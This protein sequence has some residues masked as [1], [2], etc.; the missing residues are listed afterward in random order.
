MQRIGWIGLGTMGLPMASHL[1]KA[2]YELTVYNR[3]PEKVETLVKLGAKVA[4]SPALLAK[5]QE[6][7]FTML[8]ADQAVEEVVLGKD[9]IIHGADPNTIVV[10]SSTIAASTSKKVAHELMQK[11]IHMLDAPVTGSEPQANEGLLTFMV[12]GDKEIFERCI[13]VLETM[14]KRAVYMGP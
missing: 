1:V 3:T 10:D 6:I 14:G 11:G 8:T 2:G 7:I 13:P 5:G 4:S 12:G 9:G